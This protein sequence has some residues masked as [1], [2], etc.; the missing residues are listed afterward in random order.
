MA[1]RGLHVSR[2]AHLSLDKTRISIRFFDD[3]DSG[4]GNS[5]ALFFPIEDAA[6]II[7]DNNHS[8]LS[9]RLISACMEAGTPIIFSDN[10]HHPCGIALPFHQHYAQ[11]EVSRLQIGLSLPF[12][13]RLWMQIV[14]AKI[15]NQ[16]QTLTYQQHRDAGMLA[17]MAGTVQSGDPKN[18]EARAARFYWSRLF[19][20]FSR[21]NEHDL[22]N[23][24]LN[25]GYA[26]IRAAIA[27]AIVATGFIP[28]IGLHHDGHLNPFNLVDDLIE[29]F[30]PIVD[31]AVV[32]QM[33]GRHDGTDTLSL[34]DRQ[35]MAAVLT[36]EIVISGQQT[37]MLN[38]TE[39]VAEAL[40]NCMQ[41]NQPDKLFFPQGW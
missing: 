25:Y 8:T 4:D 2:A 19:E 15:I 17:K 18:V 35:E 33:T 39:Q 34:E 1:W 6:W 10:R 9:A 28:S 22:R 13:K 16:A 3:D 26:C 7:L 23:A 38:A 31:R 41:D 24:M 27:R 20:N 29:P 32:E 11:T 14:R 30:R 12:K 40:R 5:D 37:T 36:R 21:G